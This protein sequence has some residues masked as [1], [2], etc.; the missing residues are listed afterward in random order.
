VSHAPAA[1]TRL[2][3]STRRIPLDRTDKRLS[4]Q[5]LIG[6]AGH[7]N[8][9]ARKGHVWLAGRQTKCCNVEGQLNL[10]RTPDTL[11]TTKPMPLTGKRKQDVPNAPARKRL[12]HDLGLVWRHHG[13]LQ[14]MH[15]QHRADNPVHEMH[16]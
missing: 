14:P 13:V 11:G 9:I 10:E 2:L 6:R 7:G 5:P 12:G 15:Q 3:C 8:A 4:A 16:R 1:G